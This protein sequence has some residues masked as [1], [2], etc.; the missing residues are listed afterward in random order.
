MH[1]P[2]FMKRLLFPIAICI[3]LLGWNCGNEKITEPQ[4]IWRHEPRAPVAVVFVHG[5]FGD[6][7]STW[8]GD[9]GGF[10]SLM[11]DDPEL[12][13]RTDVFAFGFASNFF[14][15]GSMDID[16]AGK[17]L[18]SMM[19]NQGITEYPAI[20]FVTHS[21]GGL[22]VLQLLSEDSALRGKVPAVF[23][24]ACPQGGSDITRI[25]RHI[26]KNDALQSM[27][28]GDDNIF[29]RILNDRWIK[30]NEKDRP[31]VFCAY[32]T[33]PTYGIQI[34][35][36]SDATHLC[37]KPAE[38]V[39]ESHISIVKPDRPTHPS[40][41]LLQ[42]ELRP[43]VRE[44][45]EPKLLTPDFE[46]GPDGATITIDN[47]ATKK[48]VRLVNPGAVGIEY[49]LDQWPNG[50]HV[51]PG[52]GKSRLERRATQI[53]G[54]APAYGARASEYSFSLSSSAGDPRRVVVRIRNLEQLQS[55]EA[56]IRSDALSQLAK[57]L[58]V[59]ATVTTLAQ[60]TPAEAEEAVV[61]VFY[62]AARRANPSAP[63]GVVWV[64]TA[65]SLERMNWNRL[66]TVA[67]E[68]ASKVE[69]G[70]A[71]VPAFQSIAGRNAAFI[72]A[73]QVAGV[74]AIDAE[75]AKRSL[76]MNEP[77]E[78]IAARKQAE[79][80]SREMAKIPV[81]KGTALT[82]RGDLARAAGR[83]LEAIRAYRDA[84]RED[85]APVQGLR[86]E[87]VE[88]RGQRLQ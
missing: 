57:N 34:V 48:E 67:L 7:L 6:T 15:A 14:R 68:E 50:L 52:A 3:T 12:K 70:F 36:W 30:L 39:G 44:D 11:Q 64:R 53:V 56:S 51:W 85:S 59:P 81:L 26:A 33:V 77:F 35:S 42:N 61:D 29:I 23:L 60:A 46:E 72:G 43:I 76:T 10:F 9:S 37:S 2:S 5:I 13:S 41:V 38:P 4:W 21:M 16:E 54:I 83:D 65:E 86:V 32:E 80:I 19:R 45:Y 62:A 58:S 22:I 24:Y 71:S 78:S 27:L 8:K 87:S 17:Q 84:G 1:P 82:V 75:E 88:S 55:Q 31:Q 49:S 73:P 47:P 20:V 74:P 66:A 25:A 79:A 28:P 18:V 63:E 40:F 69:P